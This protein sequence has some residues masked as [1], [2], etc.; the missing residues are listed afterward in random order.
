[1][2]SS[3]DGSGLARPY[4]GRNGCAAALARLPA[5][6]DPIATTAYTSSRFPPCA[7]PCAAHKGPPSSCANSTL[8]VRVPLRSAPPQPAFPPVR[9]CPP[10]LPAQPAEPYRK[11]GGT[12]EEVPWVAGHLPAMRSRHLTGRARYRDAREFSTRL[13]H[14]ADCSR[15][16]HSIRR[17]KWANLVFAHLQLYPITPTASAS[18]GQPAH[19]RLQCGNTSPESGAAKLLPGTCPMPRGDRKNDPA[20]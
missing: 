4:C 15:G 10:K 6:L 14:A 1:M 12:Q 18:A 9:T 3:L 11:L 20:A 16:G 8:L 2:S 7:A 19:A 17:R 13:W 5:T